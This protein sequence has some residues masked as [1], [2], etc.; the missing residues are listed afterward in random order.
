M[1]L[2]ALVICFTDVVHNMIQ[3]KIKSPHSLHLNTVHCKAV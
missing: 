1:F 3:I 2:A